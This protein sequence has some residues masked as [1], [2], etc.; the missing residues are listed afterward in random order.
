M[1]NVTMSERAVKHALAYL[2]KRG[3]GVGIRLAVKTTGCS[4]LMY[5]IEPV[6]TPNAEDMI[7]DV[8][9]LSIYID[10]K[11][12]VY[13]DGIE[14]DY[15]KEELNEGFVFKN[16]NVKEECGCGESFTVA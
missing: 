12:L 7:F 11:S 13:V 10:P 8:G 2:D 3:R 9:G 16:P 5:V 4:G 14:M 6:D 15:A 1:S